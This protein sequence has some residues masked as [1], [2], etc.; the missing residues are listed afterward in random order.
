[1]LPE[2]RL[3]DLLHASGFAI[4]TAE[5]CTGGLIASRIT[6]ISGS[7]RYMLGGVVAYANEIKMAQLGVQAA[8][9]I[10][11][12]AVSEPTAREMALGVQARFGATFA[13]SVTGI[14]GPSG[15]SAEKPVGLTYIGVA[16]PNQVTVARHMWGG[17]RIENKAS[18]ASAALEMLV[19]AIASYAP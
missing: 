7:S 18:S 4:C 16:T 11:H 9:L 15:G 5:S 14:A 8:T 1:M 6:D 17:S 10:A 13:V 19:A 12:G 2:Q 3:Y